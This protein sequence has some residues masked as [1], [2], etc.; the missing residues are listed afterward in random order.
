MIRLGENPYFKWIFVSEGVT[1]LYFYS[2][3]FAV[4]LSPFTLLT[5]KFINLIWLSLSVFFLYRITV[6]V[7]G[8]IPAIDKKW[9]IILFAHLLVLRFTLYNFDYIQMTPFL[10]WTMLEGWQLSKSG[11]YG[12]AGT[13]LGLGINIKTLPLVMIPYLLYRG[14]FRTVVFSVLAFGA[15]LVI[16]A[17]A[18]G[19]ER[20]LELHTSWFELLNPVN[21]EHQKEENLGIHSLTALIPSL[22]METR[23]E[24]DVQRNITELPERTVFLI[25]NIVRGILVLLVLVMSGR[26][27]FKPALNSAWELRELGYIIILIPLVFPHQ[28]KYAML[29]LFPAMVYLLWYLMASQASGRRKSLVYI[30]LVLYF[31]LAV[32][33]TDGLIGFRLNTLT[34]HFKTITYGVLFLITAMFIAQPRDFQLPE[35]TS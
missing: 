17:A 21:T 8:Y 35:R 19:W 7:A 14:H 23:G 33:S 18:L 20:N 26:R 1:L 11:K 10:L 13:L 28:Q 24:I 30:L 31:V 29:C 4:L 6:L 15:C 12:I 16:P 22:L 3:L 25:T 2:P 5:Y 27:L 32:A 9:R 34:Q